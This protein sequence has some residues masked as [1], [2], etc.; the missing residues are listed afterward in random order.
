MKNELLSNV[1]HE[2]RTP[3]TSIKGYSDLLMEDT[4]GEMNYQQ[5][6]VVNTIIR[7][8]ERLRR[9]IDSLL[10]VSMAEAETIKYDFNKTDTSGLI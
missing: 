5:L 2:L 6:K 3:L 4:L 9:L 1:S 7:N 10:Y 8:T